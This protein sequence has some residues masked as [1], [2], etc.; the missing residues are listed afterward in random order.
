MV[1]GMQSYQG[2]QQSPVTFLNMS[3]KEWTSDLTNS[4]AGV[5][6]FPESIMEDELEVLKNWKL[7]YLFSSQTSLIGPRIDLGQ[8]EAARIMTEKLLMLGHQR[9][10]LVTGY[11]PDLDAP[12]REGIYQAVTSVGLNVQQIPEVSLSSGEEASLEAIG[13]LLNQRDRHHGMDRL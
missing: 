8:V 2:T 7:P 13:T 6:I 1:R 4:L 9:L 5:V 12:K 10:A 11:Q 3:P